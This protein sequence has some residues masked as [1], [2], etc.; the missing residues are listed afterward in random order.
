MNVHEYLWYK[1][2]ELEESSNSEFGEK[3]FL[4]G[5]LQKSFVKVETVTSQLHDFWKDWNIAASCAKD[6]PY[7][8]QE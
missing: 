8:C 7:V 1:A 5:L 4:T 3:Q 2:A 6:R